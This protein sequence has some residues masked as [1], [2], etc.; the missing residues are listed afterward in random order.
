MKP[1]VAINI[2]LVKTHNN[3]KHVNVWRKKRF[4]IELTCEA[5]Y[6]DALQTIGDLTCCPMAVF[7][8][9]KHY[10]VFL[11]YIIPFMLFYYL[12]L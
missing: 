4:N 1:S 12:S 7:N 6:V 10:H 8:V 9:K 5:I 3:L 2:L 11:N